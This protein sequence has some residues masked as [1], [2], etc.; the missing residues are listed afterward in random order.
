MSLL[1]E[2]EGKDVQIAELKKENEELRAAVEPL[3]A[4]ISN[5]QAELEA[6]V[7]EIAN[8]D[9]L[10]VEKENR[11]VELQEQVRVLENEKAMALQTIQD[12]ENVINSL[13][14]QTVELQGQ[15]GNLTA[16]INSK[17]E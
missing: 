16:I 5:L 4:Q 1:E 12:K 15:I 7:G 2:K 3:N 6:K 11:I 14:A 13:N 17:N 9:A 8:K 10:L